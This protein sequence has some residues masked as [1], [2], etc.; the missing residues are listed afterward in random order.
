M[1][2]GESWLSI[3][4]SILIDQRHKQDIQKRRC[5]T[6]GVT[7][8]PVFFQGKPK[9]AEDTAL[10][11]LCLEALSRKLRC[12]VGLKSK[13]LAL[14]RGIDNL[15]HTFATGTVTHLWEAMVAKCARDLEIPIFCK[16]RLQ[17]TE[18]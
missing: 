13:Q 5:Y 9:Q 12:V 16:I 11:A 7:C 15:L 3:R 6:R 8:L 10:S 14:D 4:T 17:A 2:A 1:P 18:A